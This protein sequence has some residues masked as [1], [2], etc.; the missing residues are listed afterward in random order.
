MKFSQRLPVLPLAVSML[1]S[2]QLMAQTTTTETQ[3]INPFS[4]AAGHSYRH[5]VFPTRETYE[6]MKA[7]AATHRPAVYAPTGPQTLSYGGGQ[8]V[9]APPR[10]YL[11]VM[12]AQWGSSGRDGNGNLTL[13]NDPVGA[14]PYLQQLF[15]GLGTG[16]ELWSGTMTQYCDGSSVASG[17]TSCPGNA[18]HIGYPAGNAL[19]GIWYDNAKNAPAKASGSQLAQEAIAAA[20]HFGNTTAAANRYVQYVILSPTGT[21]PD[22]FP[23]G[24]FCAWH[25][26]TSSSY[27]NIAYTNMPYVHDAGGSCGEGYVNGATPQGAL[28]GFSIVEGHEYAETI[29]DVNPDSGWVNRTGSASNG[30]ETGDECSWV[31][32]PPEA[33]M[34]NVD[35]A[36]GS[37]AMQSTWSNDTN[38]C[39]ISHPIVPGPLFGGFNYILINPHSGKALDVKS[40]GTADGTQ[41]QIWTENYTPAQT[42]IIKA[43]GDGTYSFINPNSGKALDVNGAGTSDG[44]KVQIWDE[45]HSDAQKWL[46]YSNSDGTYLFVNPHSNKALDVNGAGTS[47]G[48]VVQIWD[49]NDGDA[50]RW[51]IVPAE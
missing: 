7:W 34:Q 22:G 13:S 38:A 32:S 24:G 14:V 18:P 3:V 42:W 20:A 5:G 26:S 19:A 33:A 35:M 48:T 36:T 49:Q 8:V 39:N 2:P 30:Q 47:D 40:R 9:S 6:Q 45:N 50:Q 46:I 10:V 37:F 31:T 28:D 16:G 23:D 15:R 51:Q 29:T 27:G 12:G 1:L 44:T 41:V 43:Q 17:A 25:S 4:P 21:H 11:V